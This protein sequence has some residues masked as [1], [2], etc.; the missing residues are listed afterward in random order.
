[1]HTL[2]HFIHLGISS[3]TKSKRCC[4]LLIHTTFTYKCVRTSSQMSKSDMQRH[5]HMH[6]HLVT[7]FQIQY[8]AAYISHSAN[9]IGKVWIQF[10]HQLKIK[11]LSKLDTL[12][13]VYQLVLEMKNT[14]IHPDKPSLGKRGINPF[15]HVS[16]VFWLYTAL[17]CRCSMSSNSPVFQFL[18]Y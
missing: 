11:E 5:I 4:I 14:K 17:Q 1:M 2:M 8:E 16:I 15:V 3:D 6:T 7:W 13:L 9:A 18:G 10:S 12:T